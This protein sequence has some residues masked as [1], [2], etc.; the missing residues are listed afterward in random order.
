MILINFDFSPLDATHPCIFSVLSIIPPSPNISRSPPPPLPFAT[1]PGKLREIQ[2]ERDL[3]ANNSCF[4]CGVDRHD[5]ET[6]SPPGTASSFHHHRTHEH[7]TKSYVYFVLSIWAQPQE[8]DNGIEMYVRKRIAANDVQ[9]FPIGIAHSRNVV[10]KDARGD[11]IRTDDAK[12]ENV[13]S[14]KQ[15][16]Q[17]QSDLQDGPSDDESNG[18]TTPSEHDVAGPRKSK[19]PSDSRHRKAFI[20]SEQKEVLSEE[21]GFKSYVSAALAE[22]ALRLD[23][24][25]ETVSALNSSALNDIRSSMLSL[26]SPQRLGPGAPVEAISPGSRSPTSPGE[27]TTTAA[28]ATTTAT[29]A[30]GTNPNLTLPLTTTGTSA[31]GTSSTEAAAYS[32]DSTDSAG[33]LI[34]TANQQGSAAAGHASSDPPTVRIIRPSPLRATAILPWGASPYTIRTTSAE[35]IA[36]PSIATHH[37]T[38]FTDEKE[39][40]DSD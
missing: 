17:Q 7:C 30:L 12:S 31:L 11:G 14:Q 13:A 21:A 19:S 34:D 32:A 26:S 15:Q 29:S 3:Q 16:Q 8:E 27:P 39:V 40:E 35:T 6:R 2:F 4:I 33:S 23:S 24:R 5:Y 18:H 25:L 20:R 10:T 1:P 36:G 28:T 38:V 22:M 37:G 9:W